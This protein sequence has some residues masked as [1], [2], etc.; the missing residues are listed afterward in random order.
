MFNG[1][2]FVQTMIRVRY[3]PFGSDNNAHCCVDVG[4]G[5]CTQH[6]LHHTNHIQK[7]KQRLHFVFTIGGLISLTLRMCDYFLLVT[8]GCMLAPILDPRDCI[9]LR[10]PLTER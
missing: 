3:F 7:D 2:L 4:V 9:S 5:K 6:N 10:T 1:F 8:T